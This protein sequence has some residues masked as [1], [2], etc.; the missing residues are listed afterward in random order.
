M[1]SNLFRLLV[2]F[3]RMWRA[4]EWPRLILPVAVKRKRFAAPL[5]VF[6]LGIISPFPIYDFRPR[7]APWPSRY[8]RLTILFLRL[9]ATDYCLRLTPAALPVLL[10]QAAWLQPATAQAAQLGQPLAAAWPEAAAAQPVVVVKAPNGL[11]RLSCAA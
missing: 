2:F 8:R 3:V 5:C 6:N 9:L 1:S 4:C 10:A 7:P 11:S